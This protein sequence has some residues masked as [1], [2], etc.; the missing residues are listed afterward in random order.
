MRPS[1]AAVHSGLRQEQSAMAEDAT[2]SG[3]LSSCRS[4]ET[5]ESKTPTTETYT[6]LEV[7]QLS[8]PISLVAYIP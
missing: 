6:R 8:V 1:K 3:M 4:T 2:L 7:N 5:T